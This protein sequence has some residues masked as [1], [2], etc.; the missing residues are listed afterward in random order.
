MI[1][2]L[3]HNVQFNVQEPQPYPYLLLTYGLTQTTFNRY[4]HS[5]T[6]VKIIACLDVR[7]VTESYVTGWYRP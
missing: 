1:L 2:L 4:M 3:S 5:C 6:L 7:V